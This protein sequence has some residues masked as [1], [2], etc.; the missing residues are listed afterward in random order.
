VAAAFSGGAAYGNRII[1]NRIDDNGLP[2]IALHSHERLQ[3]LNG[4]IIRDNVIGLNAL[5]GSTGGPG[6]GD[7]GIHHTAGILVWSAVSRITRIQVA[8]NRISWDHFGIWT[9]N[10]PHLKHGANHYSHVRV[11]LSQH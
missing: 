2:G 6:D 4:N 3:D 1:S 8:G 7:G 11:P 9:Q 5:G 10:T